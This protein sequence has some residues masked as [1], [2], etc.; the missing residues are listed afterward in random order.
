MDIIAALEPWAPHLL[1]LS[2]SFTAFLVLCLPIRYAP[3]KDRKVRVVVLVLG[4]IG[5][6]PRMQYHALS[7]ARKGGL[8]DLVG[9]NDTLPRPELLAN[10]SIQIQALKAPPKILDTSTPL[11]FV[12]F[13]P[14]KAAYQ[15][16]SLLYMLLYTIPPSTEFLLLQNPP[17][18]PTLVVAKIVSLLRGQKVVVDWHN[19]GYS[20]LQMKLKQHPIVW[21]TKLYEIIFGRGAYA[22]FTVTHSMNH[23]LRES[24]G[25]KTRIHTLYDRPPV[26]FQPFTASSRASFLHSHPTTAPFAD[27]I[28]SGRT[29]LLLSSTSWTPDEDFSLFLSALLEY[30][31]RASAENFLRPNSAPDVLAVITGKGPLREAYLSRLAD[32]EFQ[33]VAI[34]SVWLE[35]EDYPKMIA[36]ADLGVSLHTSSSGMDLPMKVVDLFGVG[37]PVAAVRFACVGELVKEGENGVTFETVDDLAGTLVRLFDPRNTKELETLKAGAMRETLERWDDNW[38]KIAAPVFGL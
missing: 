12:L 27:K 25:I 6:S 23:H 15:L 32:L 16:F 36:C 1:L 4:D 35:A 28:L 20:I 38:D 14:F 7:I 29:K 26:H 8:V 33:A 30:D 2:L 3:P 22:N 19:F 5:R 21:V 37:V 34:K 18:I 11:K 9:Y 10:P 17:A 13:A 31:R 24:W